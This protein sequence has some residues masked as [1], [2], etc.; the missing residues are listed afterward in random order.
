MAISLR[1]QTQLGKPYPISLMEFALYIDSFFNKGSWHWVGIHAIKQRATVRVSST[2][3]RF[4]FNQSMGNWDNL[5]L[6][7]PKGKRGAQDD[8][9][10]WHK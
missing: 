8:T 4:D 10:R 9:T 6:D 2:N 7:K 5:S 1:N 3:V